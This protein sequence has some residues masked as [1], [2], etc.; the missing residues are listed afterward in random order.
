MIAGYILK[1]KFLS[2][3]H[4][5]VFDTYYIMAASTACRIN[6]YCVIIN[7]FIKLHAKEQQL[8]QKNLCNSKEKNS[9]LIFQDCGPI[10][11]VY[12]PYRTNK[13]TLIHVWHYKSLA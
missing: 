10:I 4:R 12:D 2:I 11:L 3:N 13:E 7:A 6:C 8:V 9:I 5:R 1:F